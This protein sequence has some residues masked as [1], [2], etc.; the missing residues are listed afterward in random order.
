MRGPASKIANLLTC[1]TIALCGSAGAA[2][3]RAVKLSPEADHTRATF[4]LSAKVD[5]KL[6]AI[7]NPDRIVLDLDSANFAPAFNA[8]DGAGVLKALRTG[9]HGKDGARVVFDL[10]GAVQPKS[11]LLPPADGAGYRLVVDL[12]KK[13]K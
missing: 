11:F 4:E 9:K 2:E 3:I 8:P 12:Y 13:G 7:G 1:A 6:F 5:Y 10:D